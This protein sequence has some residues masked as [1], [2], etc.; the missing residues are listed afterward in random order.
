MCHKTPAPLPLSAASDAE[1]PTAPNAI[2]CMNTTNFIWVRVRTRTMTL[3]R[4]PHQDRWSPSH[5][6][7]PSTNLFQQLSHQVKMGASFMRLSGS[8]SPRINKCKYSEMSSTAISSLPSALDHAWT[9]EHSTAQR[10]WY[11]KVPHQKWKNSED[12]F[13]VAR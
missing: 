1:S 6:S 9:Y 4:A 8:T 11:E 7:L 10:C 13:L 2:V 3:A 5:P 12:V